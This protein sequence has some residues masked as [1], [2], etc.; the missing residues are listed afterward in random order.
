MIL[1]EHRTQNTGNSIEY[2]ILNNDF[3]TSKIKNR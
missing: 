2:R 1:S 3:R